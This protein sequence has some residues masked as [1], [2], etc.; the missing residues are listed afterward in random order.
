M[1]PWVAR[2]PS[3]IHEPFEARRPESPAGP[4]ALGQS[5][6]TRLAHTIETEIVPNL[7][8]AGRANRRET[9]RRGAP[10][11]QPDSGDVKEFAG[12]VLTRGDR[13]A[14]SYI[15]W[16]RL[17]GTSMESIYLDLL[18][19]SAQHLG[20]LW[21]EDHADF[22][23]VTV[24]LGR[25]QQIMREMS[26]AFLNEADPPLSGRRALIAPVAGEHHTFGALMVGDFFAR[27]GWTV[28]APPSATRRQ[29]TD[30]VRREWFCI[31]G[32]SLNNERL[33]GV[34][35]EEIATIRA[36]SC[37]REIRVMAGGNVFVENPDLAMRLGADF[38]ATD[39]RSA[40]QAADSALAALAEA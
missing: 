25:L 12:L 36:I 30:L 29:L 33:L 5:G 21:E 13:V 15:D 2:A 7:V 28:K 22:A 10:D 24:G 34:L 8:R 35:E 9:A 31:V 4:S 27:A 17:R 40:T 32:L 16:L 38:S 1:T 26:P 18:A 14:A 11:W 37:N 23:Q 3:S 6:L 19:P 39:A 20:T